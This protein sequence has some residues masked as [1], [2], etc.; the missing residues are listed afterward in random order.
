M[1]TSL[2]KQNH[3]ITNAWG[4]LAETD[5]NCITGYHDFLKSSNSQQY[6]PKLAE[7]FI[8]ESTFTENNWKKEHFGLHMHNYI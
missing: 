6:I 3:Q 1:D 8:L 2:G 7:E 4:N 5:D